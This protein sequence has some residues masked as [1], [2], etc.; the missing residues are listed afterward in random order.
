MTHGPSRQA[1]IAERAFLTTLDGSC[2]MPIAAHLFHRADGSALFRGEVLS[3]DGR[4]SWQ[5]ERAL[6]AGFDDGVLSAAGLAAGEEIRA[7]AGG[8]LPT[9]EGD[10]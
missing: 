3:P 5:T 4:E 2:R 7:A 10:A 8:A 6:A 9:F 1:A